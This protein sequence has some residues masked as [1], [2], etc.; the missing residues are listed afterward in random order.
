MGDTAKAE[1]Y[2]RHSVRDLA[3][4]PGDD[5]AF[6]AAVRLVDL[7]LSEGRVAEAQTACDSW[8]SSVPA[9]SATARMCEDLK[10]AAS[11]PDGL[12]RE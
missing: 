2:Y 11:S 8:R 6:E 5:P 9:G 3:H 10:K 4:G 12:R 1:D 7:Y